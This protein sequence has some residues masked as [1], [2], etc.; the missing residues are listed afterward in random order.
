MR[1]S[2]V[3]V[4]SVKEPRLSKSCS[5][6][7]WDTFLLFSSA[8]ELSIWTERY[9]S[10]E[11]W[12]SVK[13]R[14]SMVFGLHTCYNAEILLS[15]VP[16]MVWENDFVY[17]VVL[18]D[19]SDMTSIWSVLGRLDQLSFLYGEVLHHRAV[20]RLCS[21]GDGGALV[22]FGRRRWLLAHL[23]SLALS[24]VSIFQIRL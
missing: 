7:E 2:D 8:T 12:L 16:F 11:S 20:R 10:Y 14:T 15:S 24:V 5:H 3:Q 1:R 6:Y 22:N 4:V 17:T 13:H 9:Q 21:V 18:Q 19:Q 23:K